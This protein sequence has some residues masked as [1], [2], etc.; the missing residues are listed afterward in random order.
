ML[1]GFLKCEE[2]IQNAETP[3]D[4]VTSEMAIQIHREMEPFLLSLKVEMIESAI[5]EVRQSHI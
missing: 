4:V 3:V 5:R 1:T 2:A